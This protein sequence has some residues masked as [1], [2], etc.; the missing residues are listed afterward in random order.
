M[1]QFEAAEP[2]G[3][4]H[5]VFLPTAPDGSKIACLGLDDRY[6]GYQVTHLYVMDR[7]GSGS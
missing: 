5:G 7:D 2:R 6:Q 1:G 3:A 4:R